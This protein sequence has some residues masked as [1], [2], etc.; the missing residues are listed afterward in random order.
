MLVVDVELVPALVL[1]EESLLVDDE[2][3]V[4]AAAAGFALS[5]L[6]ELDRLSVR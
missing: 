4:A 3:A 6:F 2:A 1:D 5:L